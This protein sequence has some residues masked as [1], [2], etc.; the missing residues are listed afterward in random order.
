M[1]MRRFWA[2]LFIVVGICLVFG[3]FFYDV[4]FAGI[5]YQDPTP[6]MSANYLFHSR[7]ASVIRWIGIVVFLLG[8]VVGGAQ[9]VMRRFQSSKR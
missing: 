3:G 4:L 7:I 5:P 6:E 2:I 1:N 9:M 8:F